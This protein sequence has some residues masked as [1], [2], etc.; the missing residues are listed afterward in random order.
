MR[1]GVQLL[2]SDDLVETVLHTA[3]LDPDKDERGVGPFIRNLSDS[4]LR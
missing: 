3:V 2:G 4:M 1:E